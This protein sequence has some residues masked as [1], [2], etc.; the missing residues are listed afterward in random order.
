MRGERKQ[1]GFRRGEIAV[2]SISRRRRFL[3]DDVHVR[4][5]ESERAHSRECRAVML[6]PRY[7]CLRH[8]QAE[9]LKWDVGIGSREVQARRD[10]ALLEGERHFDE[11]GDA[12]GCFQVPEVALHRSH[13]A[14]PASVRATRPEDGPERSRLDGIAEQGSGA[15]GFHVP[16]ARRRHPSVAIRVAQYGLLGLAARGHEPVGAPVL[17]DRAAADHAEDRVPVR[18]RLG[19]RLQDHEPGSLAAHVPVGARVEHLAAP[20]RCQHAR[21]GEGDGMRG[22]ENDV[23]TS[24]E[25]ELAFPRAQA[26]AGEVHSHEGGGARGVHRHAGAA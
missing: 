5:P 25:R 7:Q 20:V 9:L 10:S 16:H 24:R 6:G 15:V 2:A 3:E 4:A 8:A 18:E 12:G 22:R 23:D 11:P 17:V 1:V 14:G 19:E 13:Q 21:L 26:A